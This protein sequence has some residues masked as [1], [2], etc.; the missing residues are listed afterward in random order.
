MLLDTHVVLWSLADDAQI[1]PRT[2]SLIEDPAV[3]K[4]V[5]AASI[6]EIEVKV[7]LGRLLV[8]DDLAA[9]LLSA[10]VLPLPI[11]WVHAKTAG[12]LPRHHGDPFD[13]MLIAQA[14][15]EGFVLVSSDSEFQKYNV[16]VVTASS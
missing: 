5:S 3:V 13:R 9:V 1:G 12:A 2:R 8:P 16:N 10:G 14:Q 6:W 7:Q 11:S 15:C 4:F